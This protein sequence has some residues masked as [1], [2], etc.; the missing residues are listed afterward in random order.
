MSSGIVVR[1][2]A[3]L[4]RSKHADP[5][6]VVVDER[7]RHAISLLSGHQGGGNALARRVAALLGGTAVI[8]TASDVRELPAL[9]LLG[10]TP[11]PGPASGAG[12]QLASG[13][14]KRRLPSSTSFAA[15]QPWLA[16][17]WNRG[18]DP[19][20]RSIGER[21]SGCCGPGGRR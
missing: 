10:Q 16:V 1:D 11:G 19:R 18:P 2:L 8:T 15:P 6:V 12:N 9:D 13:R 7:G 3:P 20:K 14:E 17:G 5:G 21:R 4:L